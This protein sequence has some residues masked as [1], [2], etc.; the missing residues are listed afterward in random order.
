MVNGDGES[1]QQGRLP[2]EIF[3][4]WKIGS[5]TVAVACYDRHLGIVAIGCQK[6]E[7]TVATT[8]PKA[9]RVVEVTSREIM[10]IAVF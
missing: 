10:M 2:Y 9:V 7:E 8:T 1:L 6:K 4:Q 5:R 3:R